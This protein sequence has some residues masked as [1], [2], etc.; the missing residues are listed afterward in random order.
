MNES[1]NQRI[2]PMTSSA[3]TPLLEAG[4]IGALLVTAHPHK[5]I[6][7]SNHS[8]GHFRR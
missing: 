3:V 4:E 7:G 6:K 2:E 1:A 8:F 5:I